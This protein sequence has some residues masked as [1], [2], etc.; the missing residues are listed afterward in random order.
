MFSCELCT[1]D[2][3]SDACRE[4]GTVVR[5]RK[6]IEM[7]ADPSQFGRDGAP[8]ALAITCADQVLAPCGAWTIPVIPHDMC[9]H[10]MG[11]GATSLVMRSAQHV[12]VFAARN[13][14]NRQNV[15]LFNLTTP[16]LVLWQYF[17]H[18]INAGRMTPTYLI[19][20]VRM[21]DFVLIT[22][23]G[24]Q[25][26]PSSGSHTSGPNRAH[27]LSPT[28]EQLRDSDPIIGIL[29][30]VSEQG[31]NFDF[32]KPFT[33][34]TRAASLKALTAS[35]SA[36]DPTRPFLDRY[37]TVHNV[38][39]SWPFRSSVTG[40]QT[41]KTFRITYDASQAHVPTFMTRFEVSMLAHFASN[42][43]RQLREDFAESFRNI[44]PEY[45][46]ERAILSKFVP[47]ITAYIDEAIA[48]LGAFESISRYEPSNPS[49]GS[50]EGC[51]SDMMRAIYGPN[52]A[53]LPTSLTSRLNS[54]PSRTFTPG[55]RIIKLTAVIASVG[56]R[57]VGTQLITAAKL[58]ATR[59]G[60]WLICEAVT[61]PLLPF[62]FYFEQGFDF[63]APKSHSTGA[64]MD[65]WSDGLVWM[66]WSPPTI[67]TTSKDYERH[68]TMRDLNM[69]KLENSNAELV[70]DSVGEFAPFIQRLAQ[71]AKNKAVPVR[72]SRPSRNFN[73]I[74]MA[75]ES[76]FTAYRRRLLPE[77]CAS[78]RCAR[79]PDLQMNHLR[80]ISHSMN[81]TVNLSEEE[82]LAENASRAFGAS[83]LCM[84]DKKR[85]RDGEEEKSDFF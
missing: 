25:H 83:T 35:A 61:W 79:V 77:L 4:C 51:T 67:K 38:P 10:D 8:S 46:R 2:G 68:W 84:S 70:I 42:S 17:T 31:G 54:A 65:K 30:D 37:F 28:T 23:V 24:E 50:D 49:L 26:P 12:H 3:R 44:S 22:R 57:N 48:H 21:A 59:M 20:S 36:W 45:S 76:A 19:D 18:F 55:D 43:Y 39:H 75:Y 9:T 56:S 73:T 71:V 66:A 1:L 33:N 62:K 5:D 63:I 41:L 64:R 27:Y 60:A 74:I 29:N 11:P 52:Y 58:L 16:A 34:A 82:T 47:A 14:S 80:K 69:S 81:S 32:C 40:L 85:A 78:Y 15:S 7:L 53:S 6:A 72:L 13:N